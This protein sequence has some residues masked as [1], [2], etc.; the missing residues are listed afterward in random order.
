MCS[1]DNPTQTWSSAMSRARS[2]VLP[3][4]VAAALLSST[5]GCYLVQHSETFYGLKTAGQKIVFVVDISGSMEG[6]NEGTLQDRVTGMAVQSGGTALGNA[7]GGSIGSLVGK[8]TASE[9]T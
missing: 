5:A 2:R 7:I 4:L 1:I 9:V 6:K 3:V 8:Q